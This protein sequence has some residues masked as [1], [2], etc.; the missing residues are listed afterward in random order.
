MSIRAARG[1]IELA[2]GVTAVLAGLV[3]I[4]AS[5]GFPFAPSRLVKIAVSDPIRAYVQQ[6]DANFQ[7]VTGAEHYDGTYYYAIAA[8]PFALGR[9]HGLIDLAPYRY[10]H[11]LHG[12]LA[13]LVSLGNDRWIP[14]ALFALSLI[15][16]FLAGWAASALARELGASAWAGLLVALSP[17]LLFAATCDTTEPLGAGL[18]LATLL[19]WR[20]RRWRIAAVL[21]VLCC[22]DKEQYVTVPVGLAIWEA[23]STVRSRSGLRELAQKV[24]V[25]ALGPL[26]LSVWYLVVHARFGQWPSSYQPGNLGAPGSGLWRSFS[27]ARR[28]ASSGDFERAQMSSIVAPALIAYV[29]LMVA[30]VIAALRVRTVLTVPVILMATIFTC[31]GQLTLEYPHEIFRTPAVAVLLS[32]LALICARRHGAAASTAT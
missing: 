7:F 22:F 21:L 25:L 8:D 30:A 13:R 18:V 24:F 11:P 6:R 10:G 12:W 19:A 3:A 5:V 2:S 23:L 29:L 9:A 14:M 26:L 27:D 32:G 17:G 4:T 20:R 15:G 31:Q 1:R 28:W 16:L